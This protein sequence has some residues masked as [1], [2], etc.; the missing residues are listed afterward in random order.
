MNKNGILLAMA[1][2]AI[3]AANASAGFWTFTDGIDESQ[4]VP[5]TGSP[6]LGAAS[7]SYDDVTNT[8]NIVVFGDDFTSAVTMAHIHGPADVG[9]NAGVVFNLGVGA[10]N[11]HDYFTENQ[12]VLSA[13]QEADFLAGLYYVNIH[14]EQHAG[15]EIR[16]QLNPVPEP[17]T[18]L[19]LALGAVAVTARRRKVRA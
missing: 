18:M 11:G 3:L 1:G 14:S 8:L 12:F 10:G 2:V 7:G 15:G 5:P 6:A 19:A 13:Q 17:G 16:G 4:E 9:A